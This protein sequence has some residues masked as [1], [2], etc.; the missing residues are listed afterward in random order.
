MD[1]DDYLD[2]VGRA[3]LAPNAIIIHGLHGRDD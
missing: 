3:E 1:H 2:L